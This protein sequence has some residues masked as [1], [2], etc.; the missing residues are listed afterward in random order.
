MKDFTTNMWQ[1][2][3]AIENM[4]K[5]EKLGFDVDVDAHNIAVHKAAPKGSNYDWTTYQVFDNLE[6]FNLFC[7]LISNLVKED[8]LFNYLGSLRK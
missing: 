2:R 5:M 1:F 4:E 8:G 6:K 7:D 3:T